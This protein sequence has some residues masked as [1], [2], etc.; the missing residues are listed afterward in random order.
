MK[1]EFETF[2]LA[3]SNF[4]CV[5]DYRISRQAA[6]KTTQ[7]RLKTPQK[8]ESFKCDHCDKVFDTKRYKERHMKQ[9][10]G[11]NKP[12]ICDIC[13][14][15]MTT[16]GGLRQHKLIH[17]GEK[18]LE[19]EFCGKKFLRTGTLRV[20]MYTHTGE[21][22]HSCTVCNQAFAQAGPW[23]KHMK[24]VHDVTKPFVCLVCLE[25]FDNKN[26][27]KNHEKSNHQEEYSD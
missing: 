4:H 16:N 14:K 24:V 17:D 9:Q 1:K 18:S 25:P 12:H 3:S 13:G 10:H 20:H 26:D 7:D 19:C 27:F 23:K 5:R 22:P 8:P 15:A 2:E 11:D 6:T 21:K